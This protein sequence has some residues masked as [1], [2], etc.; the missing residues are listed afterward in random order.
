MPSA[1]GIDFCKLL[2][3][4]VRDILSAQANGRHVEPA[5]DEA[6]KMREAM[7]PLGI[8]DK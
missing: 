1:Y 7:K 8:D 4:N 3:N 5:C 2:D 6:M